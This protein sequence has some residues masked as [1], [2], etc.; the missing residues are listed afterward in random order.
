MGVLL[1]SGALALAISH[2]PKKA[3]GATAL[4]FGFNNQISQ[5][6]PNTGGFS[7]PDVA[8][9]A[10]DIKAASIIRFTVEW[11]G[12]QPTCATMSGSPAMRDTTCV[13][14]GPYNWSWLDS[15]LDSIAPSLTARRIRLLLVPLNA[16]EWAW[17]L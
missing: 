14:P 13:R 8:T 11:A 9:A 5:Q 12:I 4:P 15:N 6:P 10:S 1:L 16:P 2:K 7:A 17:G 3:S